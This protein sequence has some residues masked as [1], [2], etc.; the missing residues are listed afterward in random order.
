MSA[1]FYTYDAQSPPSGST[2]DSAANRNK[3]DPK[4]IEQGSIASLSGPV[5][6]LLVLTVLPVAAMLY[7]TF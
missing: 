1:S 2:A 3:N 4:N 6:A 5:T 7:V